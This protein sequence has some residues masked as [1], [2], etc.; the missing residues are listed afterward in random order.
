M[1]YRQKYVFPKETKDIN[2]KVCNMITNKNEAKK[3]VKHISSDCKYK[4]KRTTCTS[5]EKLN[6][7]ACQCEYNNY[8]KCKKDYGWNPSTCICENS[9]YLKVLLIL[10]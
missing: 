9:K 4:I 1:S 2:V 10:Q 6:N 8:C 5:N 3:V 7:D